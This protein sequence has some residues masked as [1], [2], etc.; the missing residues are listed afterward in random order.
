MTKYEC[1]RIIGIRA[2]QI[3]D[4]SPI[5]IK[6]AD[7]LTNIHIAALELQQGLLDIMI[8]RPLPNDLYYEIHISKLDLPRDLD[9]IITMLSS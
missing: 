1:S 6:N 5:F 8:R 9:A 7:S 2:S 3:S 4:G